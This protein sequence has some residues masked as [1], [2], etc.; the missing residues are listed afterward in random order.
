[1]F[2]ACLLRRGG[3][4][5]GKNLRGRPWE[6]KDETEGRP[7]RSRVG[8]WEVFGIRLEEVKWE[9]WTIHRSWDMSPTLKS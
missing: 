6:G 1:M 5:G 2:I 9:T 3:L 8:V 7:G 4:Q